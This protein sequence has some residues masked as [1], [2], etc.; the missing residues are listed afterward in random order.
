[1]CVLKV[2]SDINSF[3]YFAEKTD[4][5]IDSCNNKGDILIKNEYFKQNRIVFDVSDKEWDNFKGQINDAILFLNKYKEQLKELF[6]TH[7]IEC[8]YLDFPLWSRLDGNIANQNEHI[9]QELIKIAGEL[10][11]GIEMAIYARDAFEY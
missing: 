2:Y 10:N 9:P 5:P 4:L 11:I 8:A 6:E 7:L 3:K 1:M